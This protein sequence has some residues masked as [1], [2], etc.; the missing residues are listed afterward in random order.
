[1][2]MT[3]IKHFINRFKHKLWALYVKKHM[4]CY[5]CTY[6]HKHECKGRKTDMEDCK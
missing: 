5:G 3:M 2:E 4:G 1:M 6:F